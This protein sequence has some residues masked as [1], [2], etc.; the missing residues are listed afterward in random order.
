[1]PQV[2]VLIDVKKPV[3]GQPGALSGAHYRACVDD[4]RLSEG[5]ITLSNCPI[6]WPGVS[7]R[8]PGL[9]TREI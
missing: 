1:M 9:E 2:A 6:C 5:D 8:P 7:L 3:P 4:M